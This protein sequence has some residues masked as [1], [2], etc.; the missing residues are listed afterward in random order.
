MFINNLDF[1]LRMG[2]GDDISNMVDDQRTTQSPPPQNGR[3]Y[4][5]F[6]A[7]EDNL[8]GVIIAG[9]ILGSIGAWVQQMYQTYQ[10]AETQREQIRAGLELKVGD[11]NGN[12]KIDKYYELNGQKFP[13]EVD[14][15]PV[16]EYFHR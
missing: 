13:V 4:S 10:E 1:P 12:D 6:E 16:D 15:V 5:V 11:Y 9:C 7:I 3:L 14:G 2:K 8:F